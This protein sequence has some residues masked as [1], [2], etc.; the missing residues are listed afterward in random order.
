M[1]KKD[2]VTELRR[3]ALELGLLAFISKEA[4]FGGGII[5]GLAEASN[6]GLSLTEGALYPALHRLEKNK[7]LSSEWRDGV[8]GGR[9]RKYYLIT[10]IGTERLNVLS[11]AWSELSDG[12][13]ALLEG[14]E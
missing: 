8:D 2:P 5:T 3:G 9:R 1:R 14:D 13:A 4:C 6:G 10:E 11:L 12:M 7:L